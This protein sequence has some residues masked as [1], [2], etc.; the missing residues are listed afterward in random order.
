MATISSRPIFSQQLLS[1]TG[2]QHYR[3]RANLL[4]HSDLLK[5][6]RPAPGLAVALER[7][8]V[9]ALPG[10]AYRRA[11]LVGAVTPGAQATVLLAGRCEAPQFPVLVDRVHNPVDTWVLH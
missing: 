8:A 9:V 2:H 1:H 11:Q 5:L 4:V 10:C 3:L 7:E 6:Q